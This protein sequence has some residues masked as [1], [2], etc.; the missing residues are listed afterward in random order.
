MGAGWIIQCFSFY[1][2]PDSQISD[3][4]ENCLMQ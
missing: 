3:K 1:K 4:A 2:Q